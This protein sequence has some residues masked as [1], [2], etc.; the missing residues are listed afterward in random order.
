MTITSTIIDA[1]L[2]EEAAKGTD[3]LKKAL[4]DAINTSIKASYPYLADT[5]VAALRD[6]MYASVMA[7][8]LDLST[9]NT[10]DA[11][12]TA[13]DKKL[14][15]DAILKNAY[16][17]VPA[18][19]MIPAKPFTDPSVDQLVGGYT[20]REPN[21]PVFAGIPPEWIYGADENGIRIVRPVAYGGGTWPDFMTGESTAGDFIVNGQTVTAV[22]TVGEEVEITHGG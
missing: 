16:P 2:Q 8:L 14:A 7:S 18:I 1:K 10:T 11:E 20:S 6:S 12:Q 5:A 9:R 4:Q 3:Q 19:F 13:A 15:S 22:Y 21:T 17:Y